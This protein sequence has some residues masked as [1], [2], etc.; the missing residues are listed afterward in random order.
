MRTQLVRAALLTAGGLLV[1]LGWVA[2]GRRAAD[3]LPPSGRPAV[4]FADIDCPPPEGLSRADFLGEVQ[5]LTNLPDRLPL[6]DDT[7][8]AR[9]T[10]AFAAHPRVESVRRVEVL[11]PRVRVALVYRTAVLA[12]PADGTLRA[13]DGHGVLLP[14]TVGTAGLPR[15]GGT[16]VSPPAGTPG[17]A[18]GDDRVTAAARVAALLRPDRDRVAVD[19]VTVE[20]G[21]VTLRAGG[22]RIRWGRPPGAERPGEPDAAAKVIRLRELAGRDGGLA[23]GEYDLTET[24]GAGRPPRSPA[25]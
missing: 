19:T 22:A 25:P 5:Y 4:A 6:P 8:A 14:L 23:G 20:G 11:P 7:L 2:L 15:Q 12:V 24:A 1:L 16:P 17:K 10:A 18:W 21:E 13:V 3:N 9:L